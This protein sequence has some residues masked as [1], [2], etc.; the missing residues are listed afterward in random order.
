MAASRIWRRKAK[1]ACKAAP[2]SLD[3][4]DGIVVDAANGAER[5]PLADFARLVYYRGNEL[6]PDL[7][8]ELIATRHYRVTAFPF[9]FTNSA[10]AAYVEVDA[11]TGFVTILGFWA[12]EDC[13]RVI[14]PKLVDEQVR[15]GVVQGIGGALYE[16]CLYSDDGQLLNANMADYLVPMAA[17]MPDIVVA[18]IETPTSASAL[19]AKGAG[20]AGTG[21][22]PAAVMNA[23]NDALRPLG[24]RMDRQPMTPERILHALGRVG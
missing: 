1:P 18:H 2:E 22:A 12:V 23:I 15:G 17:E 11:E 21:G 6:P 8:P 3:I 14:N 13:G 19:G 9:V 7:K 20:E 10:M 4:R 16:E 5:M 24:G